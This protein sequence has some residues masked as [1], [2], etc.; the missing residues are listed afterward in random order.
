MRN[1]FLFLLSIILFVIPNSLIGQGPEI[2]IPRE[3]IQKT[4]ELRDY[5]LRQNKN[6]LYNLRDLLKKWEN[7]DLTENE[8]SEATLYAA[9]CSRVYNNLTSKFVAKRTNKYLLENNI[10]ITLN[11]QDVKLLNE[12]F[13][14]FELYKLGILKSKYPFVID[15][16]ALF[17]QELLTYKIKKSEKIAEIGAGT[18][19]FGLSAKL[20]FEDLEWTFNEIDNSSIKLIENLLPKHKEIIS[21]KGLSV[22]KGKKNST[23]L[24]GKVYDKIIIRQ[25]LHHFKKMDEMLASIKKS[26]DKNTELY[27]FETYRDDFENEEDMHCDALMFKKDI[28]KAMTRN[29]LQLI[30]ESKI[31]EDVVLKIMKE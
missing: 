23:N 25:T 24:E 3:W 1:T 20:L 31:D 17:Y 30:S 9:Y 15:S 4:V 14:I 27:L 12:N 11:E 21:P 28:L 5:L 10:P 6:S 18:G 8:Q 26:M 22:I 7:N 13:E 2:D 19:M 16:D 29:G